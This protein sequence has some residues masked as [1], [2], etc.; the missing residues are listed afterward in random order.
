MDDADVTRLLADAARRLGGPDARGDAEV[1]L[2]AALGRER[3]WLYAHGDAMPTADQASRFQAWVTRRA[4][5]EPVAHLLGRR[6]FWSLPLAVTADTLVPRHDTE[7][8]VELALERLPG[9]SDAKVLDLGTG[10]G[11]IALA[12]AMERPR[13][14]VTAVDREARALEVACRN[15]AALGLERVRMLRGDWFSPVRGERFGLVVSNPP[16]LAQDDPHLAGELRHE[17][18]QALVAGDHGLDDL[19]G[20]VADAPAHLE[21][22]GWLLLE[23][24]LKQGAAVR[25]LLAA[26]GFAQVQTWQDLEARDRVSGGRWNG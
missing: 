8:L 3:G 2:A 9:G 15:A 25:A 6:E 17:P 13:A 22:G 1:L 7:R 19:R 5:G 24:G 23:H 26:R 12:I 10:S 4:G 21:D 11:A 16:Y 18:R 20:I 14:R